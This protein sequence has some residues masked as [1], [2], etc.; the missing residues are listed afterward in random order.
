MPGGNR[1]DGIKLMTLHIFPFSIAYADTDAGGIVY[2]ARYIEI[3]E[4]ARMK[5]LG[6]DA[7][8]ARPHSEGRLGKASLP[9]IGFVIR[10]LTVKYKKPLKLGDEFIVETRATDIGAA[11]IKIEQ[12]FVKNNEIYAILTG[13]AAYIGADM[14]PKRIPGEYLKMCSLQS[15]ECN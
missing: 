8:P 13:T 6:R 11:S 12:K 5:W 1:K 3:A 4:R 10:E 15:A 9:D 7:L 14:K 2:H